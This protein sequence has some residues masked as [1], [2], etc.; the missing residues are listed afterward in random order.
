MPLTDV[1]GNAAALGDPVA[2]VAW[3]AN[4]LGDMGTGLEAG[5]LIMTGALTR[6]CPRRQA[7]CSARSS[8]ASGRSA[9]AWWS[10]TWPGGEP[11]M[12]ATAGTRS[13]RL[14]TGSA[15]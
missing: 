15:A 2:V 7:M 14:P 10:R 9:S 6:P 5:Q 1:A 12:I 4:T 3:L 11:T 8:T 13:P